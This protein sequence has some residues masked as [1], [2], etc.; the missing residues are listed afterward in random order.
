MAETGKRADPFVAFRF[1]IK[2][3]DLAV[4]GFSDCT[5][6]QIETE[7]FDYPEGGL[8]TYTLKFP[9]R[10]KQ[11]A[12]TLKRGIVDRLLWDW[13]WDLTQGKIRFRDG[14]ITVK[15][16]SGMHTVMQWQFSRAFPNKWLGPELNAMQNT[17]AVETLEL[18]LQ[19]LKRIP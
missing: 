3:D 4:A 2:L 10:T 14:T 7:V 6:L 16:P 1:E 12:L 15:D 11:A 19:G 8:N 13:Y 18:T 5:G 17:L 9:T